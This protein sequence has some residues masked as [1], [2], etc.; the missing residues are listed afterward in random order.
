MRE[1]ETRG[2][3]PCQPSDDIQT[4]SRHGK[5]KICYRS[6]CATPTVSSYEITCCIVSF[7]QLQRVCEDFSHKMA[8]V[9]DEMEKVKKEAETAR[10]D[11]MRGKKECDKEVRNLFIYYTFNS[12]FF[13]SGARFSGGNGL[14]SF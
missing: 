10:K 9:N 14:V 8:I 11:H 7:Y 13:H 12:L 3:S 2:E 6:M 4:Q 1:F 5:A